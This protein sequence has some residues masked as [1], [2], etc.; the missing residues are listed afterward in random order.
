MLGMMK[1]GK[2]WKDVTGQDKGELSIMNWGVQLARPV[3]LGAFSVS[4]CL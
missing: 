3:L 2:L 4:L 1:S